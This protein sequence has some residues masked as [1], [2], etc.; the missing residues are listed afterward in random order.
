MMTPALLIASALLPAAPPAADD[1]PPGP[2]IPEGH[3]RVPS[4]DFG[5]T[6]HLALIEFHIDIPA[7]TTLLID[8]FGGMTTRIPAAEGDRPFARERFS[9]VID[10]FGVFRTD[11]GSGRMPGESCLRITKAGRSQ[12]IQSIPDVP[13]GLPTE[14]LVEGFLKAGDYPIGPPLD[15]FRLRDTVCTIRVVPNDE[16]PPRPQLRRGR[17]DL[18][19]SV[20]PAVIP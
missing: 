15:V 3:F 13:P 14:R 4:S 20:D 6:A 11:P 19:G 8:D 12:S 17:P 1:N 5:Q 9:L 2:A 18:L 16:V 7:G 10:R